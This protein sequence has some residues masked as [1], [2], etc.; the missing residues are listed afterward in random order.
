MSLDTPIKRPFTIDDDDIQDLIDSEDISDQTTFT[1]APTPTGGATPVPIVM[2]VSKPPI[3]VETMTPESFDKDFDYIRANLKDII[4][5]GQDALHRL[6]M[7]A[8][9]SDQPR[10]YEVV[11]ILM[12]EIASANKDLLNSHKVKFETVNP[13]EKQNTVNNTQNNTIFVGS[14]SELSKV[15]K[16]RTIDQN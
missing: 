9:T 16:G 15:L 1:L 2:P 12:R 8:Q 4:A 10:A 13:A 7:L 14:T 3:T 11:A 6:L 5:T